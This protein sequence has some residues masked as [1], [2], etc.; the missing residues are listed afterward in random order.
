M[1]IKKINL[2]NYR[3]ARSVSVNLDKRLNVI[4]GVNGSGKST[5]L[6]AT[7]ILLSWLARR[8]KGTGGSARPVLEKDITNDMPFSKI[9]IEI[10]DG[11]KN[12]SWSIVKHRKKTTANNE[13]SS[14]S[15]LNNY[16]SSWYPKI[17][18]N[19]GELNLPLFVYYPVNRAILDIPL[20]IKKGREFDLMSAYDDAL[21]NDANFR[22][23]FEWF[24]D[25]EDLENEAFKKLNSPSLFQAEETPIY[26]DPQLVAVRKAIE[27]LL[28]SFKNLKVQR[29]PLRMVIEKNGSPF[30]VDQLSDGEKCL[31]AMVGDL[32]RR[33]AIANP[34]RENPLEGEGVVLIDE[35]DLHLHPKWQQMIIDRLLKIF[36]HCQ[37]VVSTHSPHV[38]NHVQPENIFMLEETPNGLSITNPNESYGKTVERVLEDLMGLETTRPIAIAEKLK[39]V[40][41]Y[42]DEDKLKDARKL[43]DEIRNEINDDPDLTKADAIITRKEIIGK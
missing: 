34:A 36:P 24:R 31:M 41:N 29:Q 11:D 20:R 25:R 4:V 2:T 37:F 21:T 33:M 27:G 23:F 6:D 16:A 38:I 9:E 14:L 5:L 39:Q 15:E 7:V 13:N 18:F 35:I 19:N 42:I 43:V 12:A 22:T 40:Y 17:D 1:N 30:M 8:L 3:G 32:A 10:S 28:P 26:P